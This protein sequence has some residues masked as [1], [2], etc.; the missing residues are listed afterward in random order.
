MNLLEGPL[1]DSP[2]DPP[3]IPLWGS[4]GFW[5][6]SEVLGGSGKFCV[7]LLRRPAEL[8]MCECLSHFF[9]ILN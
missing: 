9:L 2:G 7:G 3:G 1:K 8:Y 5:E 4:K 6:F